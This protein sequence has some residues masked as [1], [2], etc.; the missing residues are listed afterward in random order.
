MGLLLQLKDDRGRLRIRQLIAFALKNNA[1]AIL[2]TTRYIQAELGLGS[3]DPLPTA[4]FALVFLAVL[5][6][7]ALTV[8]ARSHRLR[9]K[10]I[11]CMA[12]LQ[13]A[14]LTTACDAVFEHGAG[15]AA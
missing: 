3:H 14:A 5:F 8:R 15:L 9:N 11:A 13:V 12:L 1:L 6:A 4:P 2:G 7:S 10:A